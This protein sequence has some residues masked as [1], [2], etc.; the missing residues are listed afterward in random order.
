[1]LQ[2]LNAPFWFEYIFDTKIVCHNIIIC[3]C[4]YFLFTGIF[5]FQKTKWKVRAQFVKEEHKR[6]YPHYYYSP[7]EA[8]ERK[9]K[10]ISALNERRSLYR[11]KPQ[12]DTEEAK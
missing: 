5:T 2:Y 7:R 9:Q 3:Y 12:T 8:S 1:M 4:I 6:M 10:Y 11:I